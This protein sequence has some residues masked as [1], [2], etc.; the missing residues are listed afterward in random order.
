MRNTIAA[1]A[2]ASTPTLAFAHEGHGAVGLF[3]HLMDLA[4]AIALVGVAAFIIWKR[5]NK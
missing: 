1:L 2:L 3:H 5:A 4:P